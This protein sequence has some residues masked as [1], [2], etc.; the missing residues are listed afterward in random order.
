MWLEGLIKLIKIVHVTGTR[1]SDL[2]A[3][4]LNLTYS[5][6]IEL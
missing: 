4:A 6:K 5:F 2:P 3:C 1:I